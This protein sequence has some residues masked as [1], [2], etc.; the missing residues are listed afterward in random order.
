LL[1]EIAVGRPIASGGQPRTVPSFSIVGTDGCRT[2][3]A[4]LCVGSAFRERK[5]QCYRT[6]RYPF[7]ATAY[8]PVHENDAFMVAAHARL[9]S[10]C[11][12]Q[13]RYIADRWWQQTAT[14]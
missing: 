8:C 3:W 5:G 9:E 1:L 2:Q 14:R 10:R 7:V 12:V 11:K 4:P 13:Q 6:L